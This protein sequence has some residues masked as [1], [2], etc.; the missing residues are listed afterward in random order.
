MRQSLTAV[1]LAVC[2]IGCAQA[3]PPARSDPEPAPSP[4][5]AAPVPEA[6]T[7]APP[8]PRGS[9]AER[10]IDGTLKFIAELRELP[11]LG[12]VAGEELTREEMVAHVRQTLREEV[13]PEVLRATNELLFLAG[14]VDADFDYEESLLK[15]LGTELAGFYDPKQR[16]MYLGADLEPAEW[17]ATLVHELVHALQDQH[18]GLAAL[19]RWRP[20]SSDRMG[21]L[22]SLAEGD[23]TSAMLDGLMFGSGRTSLDLP[24][25]VLA[26]QIEGL[27]GADPGVPGIV[28]RSVVAP[29]VDGLRFVHALRRRGGWPEVDAAWNDPPNSS[30]QV[31][32]P[33][34]YFAREEP[35]VVPIPA[36]PPAGP[37]TLLYRDVE[38]EQALGLLLE[39]WLPREQ[40]RQAASDWAGDR[41][42]LYAEEGRVAFAWRLRFDSEVAAR[43]AYDAA[44]LWVKG[45]P[46]TLPGTAAASCRE[47]KDRGP[48][49]AAVTGDTL[50]AVAG[51]LE[52]RGGGAQSL[53]SCAE[54]GRWLRQLQQG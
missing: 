8:A 42:A 4:A 34:K 3:A 38:G 35:L 19:T 32:H 9:R 17:R 2:G 47:R 51:P 44:K 33:E 46:V 41:L 15:V 28:K 54:A 45:T 14:V 40:A 5:P 50:L 16:R 29:Y 30:E 21:A 37:R 23:A 39:E 25:A 48:L 31:L 18:Y 20:D 6:S 13:P 36:A 27:Q 12:T 26:Q 53:S 49:A 52:R 43:R 1:L 7:E 24:E 11:A 22:H 10:A